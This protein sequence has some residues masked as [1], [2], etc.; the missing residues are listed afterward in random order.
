MRNLLD[1]NA[2]KSLNA[3][4]TFHQIPLDPLTWLRPFFSCSQ[5]SL[6]RKTK[7]PDSIAVRACGLR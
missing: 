7:N 1:A 2:K 3:P 6:G 4:C 5:A